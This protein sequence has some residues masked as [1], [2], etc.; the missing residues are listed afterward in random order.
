[1]GKIMSV[2]GPISSDKLGF[3]SIHEHIFLDLT[4]D[5]WGTN[6]LLNDFQLAHEELMLYKKAGGQT[7]IDQT[8][9]GLRGHDHELFPYKHSLAIRKISQSTG[10]NII[11][12]TGWYREPY[13]DKHIYSNKTDQLAEELVN[14]V[15]KGIEGT[16]VKAGILGEIGTHFTWM[17]AA[18]ERVFR[19][20]ARAHN[21]TGVPIATHALNCPVGLAQLDIF[22]EEKVDLRKVIIGHCQTW[23]DKDYHLALAK[24]GA[25]L[26]FDRMGVINEYDKNLTFDLIKSL[27]DYGY[28]NQ[29][30]LGQDVCYRSDYVIYGGN[31]YEYLPSKCEKDIT[32]FGIN[33]EDYYKMVIDNPRNALNK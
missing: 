13:Y 16:D 15:E 4:K 28:T 24:R 29:I 17:S 14:D 26:A 20:V 9:G 25:F 18:E 22:Q 23:P 2:T 21:K 6:S 27:I 11:L 10:I 1:M 31:G 8:T 12:G 30:L 33:R 32:D 3:T 5:K 7:I 19:A